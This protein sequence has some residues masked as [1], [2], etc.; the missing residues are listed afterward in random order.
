MDKVETMTPLNPA[1]KGTILLFTGTRTL[2]VT[3]IME[4]IMGMVVKTTPGA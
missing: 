2:E 3:E 1:D 4:D